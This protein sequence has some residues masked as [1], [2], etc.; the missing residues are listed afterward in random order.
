[1]S[2]L[3]QEQEV[4]IREIVREEAEM[5]VF[6]MASA[7]AEVGALALKDRVVP[8]REQYARFLSERVAP[9]RDAQPGPVA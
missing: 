7:Q 8:S 2:A 5:A 6:A 4:R 1:M 9:S 3:T